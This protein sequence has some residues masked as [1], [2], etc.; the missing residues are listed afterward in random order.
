MVKEFLNPSGLFKRTITIEDCAIVKPD[1]RNDKLYRAKSIIH[2]DLKAAH[3]AEGSNGE[4]GIYQVSSS[5]GHCPIVGAKSIYDFIR[6]GSPR[7]IASFIAQAETATDKLTTP[8]S[9]TQEIVQDNKAMF[10]YARE[11]LEHFTQQLTPETT[12]V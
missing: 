2:P 6:D 11:L 3:A 4:Q 12:K 9:R 8:D 10:Q 5:G 1:E 7:N